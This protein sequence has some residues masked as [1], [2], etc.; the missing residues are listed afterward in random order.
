MPAATGVLLAAVA[1]GFLLAG[2]VVGVR[3]AGLGP[4]LAAAAGVEASSAMERS[5]AMRW[6]MA[7]GV[8]SVGWKFSVVW[9]GK[10]VAGGFGTEENECLV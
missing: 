2:A 6:V 5:L 3:F 1:T 9:F 10:V 7:L 4:V 8:T